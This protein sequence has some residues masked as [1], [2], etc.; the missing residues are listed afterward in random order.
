MQILINRTLMNQRDGRCWQ[1]F[2]R[3]YALRNVTELLGVFLS[4]AIFRRF[5]NRTQNRVKKRKKVKFV[6]KNNKKKRK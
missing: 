5:E 4:K 1:S 2:L 6:T 3:L